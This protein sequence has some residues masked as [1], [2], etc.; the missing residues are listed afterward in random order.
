MP[1]QQIPVS[2]RE[3]LENHS[4]VGAG[5]RLQVFVGRENSQRSNQSTDL[6]DE[7]E[8]RRIINQTDRAQKNPSGKKAV[9]GAALRIE[10][11]AQPGRR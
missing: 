4:S 2:V 11:P 1:T 6:K 3:L 8:K 10:Q 5:H 9:R 7:R